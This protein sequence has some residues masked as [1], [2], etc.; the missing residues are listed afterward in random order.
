MTRGYDFAV[1]D[2][3]RKEADQIEREI[4]ES[5]KL[6]NHALPN[7]KQL[8]ENIIKEKKTVIKALR[9]IAE[10]HEARGKLYGSLI[11][12]QHDSRAVPVS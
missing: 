1:A 3:Y 6:Q 7:G 11:S 8:I 2:R 10:L 4:K 12:S 5:E 9:N